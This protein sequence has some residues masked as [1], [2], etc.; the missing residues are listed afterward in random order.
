M[1]S[2]P[3]VPCNPKS[4]PT[5]DDRA[6]WRAYWDAQGQSWRTEPEI[7]KK[8]QKFLAKHLTIV[9]DIERSIYPFSEATLTRADVEWLLANHE[10][11]RGPIDWSDE[12]Q[13]G[14]EGLDLRG[15]H[16]DGENL[17]YLPLARLRTGV[18]WDAL[19]AF[20]GLTIEVTF[21]ATLTQRLFGK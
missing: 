13:H 7:D 20:V 4:Y 8:Q 3:P 10:H 9:P 1:T 6:E 17:S 19:E 12:Q 18:N 16:L 5:T 14:R 21:I 2:L 15:V 11:G